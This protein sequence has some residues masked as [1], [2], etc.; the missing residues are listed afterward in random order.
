MRVKS[1]GG[2]VLSVLPGSSL[3][4]LAFDPLVGTLSFSFFSFSLLFSLLSFGV[5]WLSVALVIRVYFPQPKNQTRRA[6]CK[7]APAR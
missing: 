7:I 3:S 2:P 6:S 1:K 4:S 5:L